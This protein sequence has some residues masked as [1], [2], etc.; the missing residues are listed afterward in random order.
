KGE[1]VP[2]REIVPSQH[3]TEPP[4]RYSEASLV[5]ELERLGIGRPSTYA[6][7]ISTLVD[8]H[9]TQLEQRRFF[10]TAL[11]ESVERVMV[12]QF[13]DIFN[14]GFTSAMEGELDK[15]EEGTLGWQKVLK[16]FYSPFAKSLSKVDAPALIAAAHDLSGIGLL[17]CPDCG[18]KLEPRGG[19][20][21]PFLAC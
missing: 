5:K 10:P 16:D 21:G 4:P 8:R 12:K 13:P 20:F 14:V 7:I 15:V 6:Q 11:G 17:R 19:F 1:R 3:F 2:V 9:Y 18:G